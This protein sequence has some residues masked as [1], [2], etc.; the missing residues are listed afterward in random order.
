MS[1]PPAAMLAGVSQEVLEGA[2]HLVHLPMQG[3]VTSF[4]ISCAAAVV[5][6][7]ARRCRMQSLGSQHE[8]ARIAAGHSEGRH[9]P[10]AH[11][12]PSRA[13]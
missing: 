1:D 4:N 2:D 10:T 9:A 11:S 3:F 5:L 8:L 7:E 6:W 13:T 12:K